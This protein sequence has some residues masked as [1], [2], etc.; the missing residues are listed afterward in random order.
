MCAI[1][2][3]QKLKTKLNTTDSLQGVTGC[4]VHQY[5]QTSVPN[6][7]DQRA[8]FQQIPKANECLLLQGK[9]IRFPHS[10]FG[11]GS[12]W[13]GYLMLLLW[14]LDSP[15]FPHLHNRELTKQG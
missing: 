1:S 8:T 5:S 15:W 14:K 6:P 7:A 13:K 12:L 11:L 10:P 9:Q 3:K 2:K 4:S